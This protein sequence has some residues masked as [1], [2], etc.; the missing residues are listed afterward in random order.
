LGAALASFAG[1][2]SP[3]AELVRQELTAHLADERSNAARDTASLSAHREMH[4][5]A[6]KA[7]RHALLVMRSN[8]E[9]GDDA[10]HRMEEE[11]DWTEMGGGRNE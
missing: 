1:D 7:A 11:L 6:L 4:R 5:A 8:D 3:A 10:F 9:I 2:R